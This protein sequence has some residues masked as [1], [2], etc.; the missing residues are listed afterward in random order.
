MTKTETLTMIWNG[1]ALTVNYTPCYSKSF[2]EIQ[3]YS[4]AHLTIEADGRQRLPMTETGFRSHFTP[5]ANVDEY[6]GAEGFVRACLEHAAQSKAW[7]DF[8]VKSKQ[9]A[10]F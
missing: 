10:L 8:F 5:K 3:G 7:K 2:R 4:L 6:G 1:I 9:L